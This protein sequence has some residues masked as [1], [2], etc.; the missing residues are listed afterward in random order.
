MLPSTLY[1]PISENARMSSE[2]EAEWPR[3]LRHAAHELRTP[4]GVG[5]GYLDSSSPVPTVPSQP[6]NGNS[7]PNL[8]RR[9]DASGP[10]LMR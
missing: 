1:A 5:L 3:L 8:R 4:L 2:P 6:G 10:S 7:L 9:W